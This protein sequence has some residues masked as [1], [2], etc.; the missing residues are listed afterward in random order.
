MQRELTST[1]G[2]SENN[3]ELLCD[4]LV[5]DDLKENSHLVSKII[6]RLCIN[7]KNLYSFIEFFRKLI[8]NL[9]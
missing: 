2:L 1:I 7:E 4:L 3:N 6:M 9:A 5:G 8:R